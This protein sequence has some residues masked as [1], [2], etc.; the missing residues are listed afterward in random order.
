MDDLTELHTTVIELDHIVRGV[1]GKNGLR[2]K[3]NELERLIKERTDELDSAIKAAIEWGQNIW[4]KERPAN[5]IGREALDTYKMEHAKD[6][7]TQIDM[8]KLAQDANNAKRAG[9]VSI[10][11][12]LIAGAATVATVLLK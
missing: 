1:D 5:C 12:T 9:N 10:I 6:H 4:N 3:F 8:L 7:A 11:V 2:G